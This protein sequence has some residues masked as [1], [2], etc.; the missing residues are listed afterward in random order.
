[1]H[2]LQ[3]VSY[4]DADDEDVEAME[5]L[6]NN[7]SNSKGMREEGDCNVGNDSKSVGGASLLSLDDIDDQQCLDLDTQ[8]VKVALSNSPNVTSY[9]YDVDN[10]IWCQ[11]S[12]K[13]VVNRISSSPN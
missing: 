8:R 2:S 1:V 13:V 11:I 7:D 4:D 9:T 10:E 5:C 6:E 12:L 3:H